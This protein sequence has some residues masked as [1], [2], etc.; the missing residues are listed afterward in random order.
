MYD[1]TNWK[2]EYQIKRQKEESFSRK[3]KMPKEIKLFFETKVHDF[4]T[5]NYRHLR[6]EL[7]PLAKKKI[8]LNGQAMVDGNY[9]K[10]NFIV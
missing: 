2:F 1:L 3:Y 9:Q 5:I 4:R 8:H 10:F 6:V 7:Y